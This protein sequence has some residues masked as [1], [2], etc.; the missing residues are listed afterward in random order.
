MTG[1]VSHS[2]VVIT[3]TRNFWHFRF[4]AVQQ[5]GV[6]RVSEGTGGNSSDRAQHDIVRKWNN[7]GTVTV[8]VTA[9]LESAHLQSS[10][11]F[12]PVFVILKTRFMSITH[13]DECFPD[14]DVLIQQL[15]DPSVP[16]EVIY[17]TLIG[18]E[19]YSDK[20]ARRL[21]KMATLADAIKVLMAGR[22]ACVPPMS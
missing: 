2:L 16:V 8:H 20:A 7:T 4:Q 22:P 13:S 1:R 11:K 15:E 18:K 12:R 9:F 3:T 21:G 6:G 10:R 14:I 19:S 5:S 17:A